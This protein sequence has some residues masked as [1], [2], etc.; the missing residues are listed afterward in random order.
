MW[1]R[2]QRMLVWRHRT[3]AAKRAVFSFLVSASALYLFLGFTSTTWETV[4]YE[5]DV[6]LDSLRNCSDIISTQELFPDS[7]PP[8]VHWTSKSGRVPA[9]LVPIVRSW[10]LLL[11]V[12][13]NNSR[14]F[15]AGDQLALLKSNNLQDFGTSNGSITNGSNKDVDSFSTDRWHF[16]HWDDKQIS[17]LISK[18][19]PY[20][21]QSYRK[22]VNGL[23]RSDIGRLV[24]LHHVGGLYV[25]TDVELLRDPTP[26]L[27]PSQL[28]EAGLTPNF[29]CESA[30]WSQEPIEHAAFPFDLPA[31]ILNAVMMSRANHSFLSFVLTNW[32]PWF[33]QNWAKKRGRKSIDAVHVTGPVMLQKFYKKYTALKQSDRPADWCGNM[34]AEPGAFHPLNDVAYVPKR[35]KTACAK[36]EKLSKLQKQFCSP[37]TISN[38]ELKQ[39]PNTSYTVHKFMHLSYRENNFS[40]SIRISSIVPIFRCKV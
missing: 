3:T 26:L 1:L 10:R 6:N 13:I 29:D 16:M 20:L 5:Y 37:L 27:R 4:T 15:S 21:V 40:N 35:L 38:L 36:P 14:N 22:L 39:I 17:E 31:L 7:I 19:Y 33:E 23:E 8:L 18:H 11:N 28:Q 2:L 9:K 25:D 12:R 34:L 32:P 30:V 24:V